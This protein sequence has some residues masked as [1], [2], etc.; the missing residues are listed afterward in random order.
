MERYC[1]QCGAKLRSDISAFCSNCGNA[2]A[3][4]KFLTQQKKTI[5]KRVILFGIVVAILIVGIVVSI[6]LLGVKS[7]YNDSDANIKTEN[8]NAVFA[9]TEPLPI[10]NS[11]KPDVTQP[12]A[13][14]RPEQSVVMPAEEAVDIYLANTDIW[15]ESDMPMNGHGYCLLDLDFD[16][17]L[18]LVASAN[19]GSGRFSINTFYRIN[20]NTKT[21]E[22]IQQDESAEFAAYDIYYL[23]NCV[24]LHKTEMDG[25]LFYVCCDVERYSDSEY[26]YIY[27]K[28]YLQSNVVRASE[29]YSEYYSDDNGEETAEYSY[30][31]SEDWVI[32]SKTEYDKWHTAFANDNT[33]LNLQWKR[34]DGRE[35]DK[36]SSAARR[37]LLLDAYL[38]FSYDGFSFYNG[39]GEIQQN[40]VTDA[41]AKEDTYI[42]NKYNSVTGKFENV[43]VVGTFRIPQI[44]LDSADV[45]RINEEIYNKMHPLAEAGLSEISFSGYPE[46]SKEIVYHWAVNK[47]I[48]SLVVKNSS[49]VDTYIVYNISVSTGK[50]LNRSAVIKASGLSQDAYYETAKKVLGSNY[51]KSWDPSDEFFNSQ[52]NVDIFNK[53]LN[54]TVANENIDQAYPYFND[55]GQ[56]CV[57]VR[58]YSIAA[59]DFYWQDLNMVD[60]A[61]SPYYATEAQIKQEEQTGNLHG[62]SLAE[63]YKAVLQQYSS[64]SKYAT[65]DIDKDGMPELIVWKK[66]GVYDIYTFDGQ[67]VA[68]VDVILDAYYDGLY[69]Y[70]GNGIVTHGGGVGSMHMEYVLLYRLE[71]NAMDD[72]PEELI[73]TETASLE[74]LKQYLRSFTPIN[75]FH[76]VTDYAYLPTS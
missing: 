12:E 51:W 38:S 61:L 63:Q 2:V 69:E 52:S 25:S 44:N 13:E 23:D 19:D 43:Q 65:Y 39:S 3:D 71:N 37:Q 56:L 67:A 73:S 59:A 15:M 49:Y 20:Q 21:V 24:S 54:R 74:E 50:E 70:D 55:R 26:F 66:G 33:D 46:T 11:N 60:Y 48:L 76:P 62:N 27:G 40:Y 29:L 72:W 16:G 14:Q 4:S 1:N 30:Y 35:F 28:L 9:P 75:H 10:E 58:Q 18:E 42:D 31:Q 57:V 47:D 36:G 22:E 6:V 32:V 5:D 17:V 7:K 8:E 41:Y 68:K 45:K 34:V 64:T 53:A